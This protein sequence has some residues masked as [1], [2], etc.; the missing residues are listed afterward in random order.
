[1]QTNFGPRC[2]VLFAALAVSYSDKPLAASHVS[3]PTHRRG[4]AGSAG[5]LC[6]SLPRTK[7]MESPECTLVLPND[8]QRGRYLC[9]AASGPCEAG[10]RQ[11]ELS[12]GAGN[13]CR[14]RPGCSVVADNCYCHCRGY[15]RT[16]V[17]DGAEAQQ[18]LCECAGGA[19]AACR[20]KSG[21]A[22]GAPEGGASIGSATMQSD[23]VILLQLRAEG[24]GGMVGDALL[25]YAP[26]HPQYQKIL[27]HVGGLRPGESKPVPPWPEDPE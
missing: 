21:E 24:E 14:S 18:C 8:Q 19:P 26:D 22:A 2:V 5:E 15:G 11:T 23:R 13:L 10:V 27:T 12:R 1:M 9:R 17:E 6:D 4:V 3:D 7:C 25:T 16:A 20:G